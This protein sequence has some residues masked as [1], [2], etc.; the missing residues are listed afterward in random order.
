VEQVNPCCMDLVKTHAGIGP[1][2]PGQA[3]RRQAELENGV[4]RRD[5]P[6][7]TLTH[8]FRLPGKS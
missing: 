3:R 4:D 6:R 5:R 2:Q 8:L 1:A 7:R